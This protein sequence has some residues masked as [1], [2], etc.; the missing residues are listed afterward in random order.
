M[1]TTIAFALVIAAGCSTVSETR[2]LAAPPREASCA[3]D[4]V[5]AD[6]TSPAFNQTWDTLGYVTLSKP[7]AQDPAAEANRSV[8]RPRACAMGGTA[9]AVALNSA[10]QTAFGTGS[11]LAF[12]VLRPKQAALAPTR[13]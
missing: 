8:V 5:Q 7:A 12:M 2:M 6:I 11:S 13:F 9:I 1:K 3:L 4:L 10:N